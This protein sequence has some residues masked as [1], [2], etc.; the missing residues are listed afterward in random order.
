MDCI[1]III[2]RLS[3][4]GRGVT[5]N[6]GA[7]LQEKNY[8]CILYGL[9]KSTLRKIIFYSQ[10]QLDPINTCSPAQIIHSICRLIIHINMI[11]LNYYV[12]RNKNTRAVRDGS[13]TV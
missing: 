8:H 6:R 3:N 11:Y 1:K 5:K 10:S 7:C 9:L 4:V 2:T 13:K 12:R